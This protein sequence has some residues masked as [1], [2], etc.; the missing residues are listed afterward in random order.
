[1]DWLASA[2]TAAAAA[3]TPDT[4]DDDNYFHLALIDV[5][6][7]VQT[8]VDA[9]AAGG[10]GSGADR[11]PSPSPPLAEA[12]SHLNRSTGTVVHCSSPRHR[13]CQPHLPR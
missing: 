1:M 7:A 6:G 10:G 8:V 3:A 12:L 11:Q 13:N 4:P 5:A 9:G 2:E